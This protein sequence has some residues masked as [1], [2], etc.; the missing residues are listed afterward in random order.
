MQRF[1]VNKQT[2]VEWR[3]M[4]QIKP[5]LDDGEVRLAI[6]FFAFTANNLTYAVAGDF[7]G[8]WNFFPA[9]GGDNAG[10]GV[11]PMWGHARVIESKH[12]EIAVGERLYGYLPMGTGLDV[13]PGNVSA[14]GFLDMTDYRQPMSPIYNQYARLAAD[15]EHDPAKEAERMIYG[16]LFKLSL[17]HI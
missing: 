4:E 6:D 1:E 7:L 13:V 15:P 3:G 8:Y 5:A 11:V 9:K 2:F 16:P 10:R 14:S 12:D 17:I